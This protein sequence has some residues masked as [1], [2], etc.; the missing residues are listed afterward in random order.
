MKN[1][2]NNIHFKK[3]TLTI[4]FAFIYM[5]TFAQ[6]IDKQNS[7]LY[8]SEVQNNVNVK[9]LFIK[10]PFDYNS[11]IVFIDSLNNSAITVVDN[12]MDKKSDDMY[13]FIDNEK[14]IIHRNNIN[15]NKKNIKIVKNL[16]Y[17][18][19]KILKKEYKK[20]KALN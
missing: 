20:M 18:S 10:K 9:I 16:F 6:K 12:D 3:I 7:F 14:M 2:I 8:I 4:F 17:I 19:D 15:G 1:T 5:S 11:Y 13:F